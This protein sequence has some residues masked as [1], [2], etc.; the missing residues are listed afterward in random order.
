MILNIFKTIIVVLISS[1]FYLVSSIYFSENNLTQ[2]KKNR[3]NIEIN[4][5]K[6]IEKLPLLKNN[7]DNVIIFSSGFEET[8][9]NN[10][11]RNFWE[12]FK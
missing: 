8:E 1:F 4:N 6:F 10:F 3:D 5:L 7:T 12:L 2:I 9:N 11:K